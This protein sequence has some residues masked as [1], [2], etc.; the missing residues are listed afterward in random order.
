MKIDFHSSLTNQ[1]IK[2][3]DYNHAIQVLKTFKIKNI[4]EYSD[5]YL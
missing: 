3:E 5:L 1:N 2:D 4:G